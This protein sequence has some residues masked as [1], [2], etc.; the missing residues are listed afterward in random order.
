MAGQEILRPSQVRKCRIGL[1]IPAGQEGLG[2]RDKENLQ[3]FSCRLVEVSHAS[4]PVRM[5]VGMYTHVVVDWIAL[6][7]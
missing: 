4:P 3:R 2:R 1:S 7:G 5:V 6:G